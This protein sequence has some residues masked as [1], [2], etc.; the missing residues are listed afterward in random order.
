MQICVELLP[1][2]VVKANTGELLPPVPEDT[3][4]DLL[5][6]IRMDPDLQNIFDNMT[7][8]PDVYEQ[9]DDLVNDQELQGILDQ[10]QE[11][12]LERELS[13]SS[14]NN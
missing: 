7:C 5:D 4:Q 1:P 12:P 9:A 8:P 6:Q 13:A 10:C 3:Y 2:E 11:T 14:L